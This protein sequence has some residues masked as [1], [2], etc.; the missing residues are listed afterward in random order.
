[1]LA[2][3]QVKRLLLINSYSR[4]I[5]IPQ[6]PPYAGRMTVSAKINRGTGYVALYLRIS[7]DPSGRV[8]GVANQKVWG[9]TYAAEQWPGVRVETFADND[10]SATNGDHRPDYERL[11]T[12]IRNG[13]VSYL[14]T[15]ETSR[16]ERNEIPWFELAA[17]L[18][19]VGISEVHTRRDG[20]VVVSDVVAGIRAVLNAYETRKLKQRVNDRLQANAELGTPSGATVFGYRR[21]LKPPTTEHPKGV[22]TLVQDKSEAAIVREAAG[23]VLAGWSLASI[24]TDLNTRGIKGAH[25]GR[26]SGHTVRLMVT[27]HIIAGHRVHRG[28][29]I[30]AGNWDAVL[31]EDMWKDVR[32][33]LSAPRTVMQADGFTYAVDTRKH[34]YAPKRYLLTGGLAVCAVCG[35]RLIATEKQLKNGKRAPYYL[36]HKQTGAPASHLGIKAEPFEAFVVDVLLGTLDNPEF[37]A[38]WASDVHSPQ[39]ARITKALA[40]CESDRDDLADLWNAGDLTVAEWNRARNGVSAREA[41]LR[42]ELATIPPTTRRI[43]PATVREAW[44]GMTLDEKRDTLSIFLARVVVSR[45]TPGAMAFD[46]GRVRLDFHP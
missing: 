10:L 44:A 14:W 41:A 12:A 13:E 31:T 17:E 7:S 6:E 34:Q 29:V 4:L 28:R 43:D 45:A 18:E 1:M 40:K 9:T 20:I 11:R 22:K 3:Q 26:F 19:T 21:A 38:R 5:A 36:C 32:D 25:G 37:R 27:N 24:A 16:L 42:T 39:R 8:E 33:K 46:G 30:G 2:F 15:V 23:R 35:F